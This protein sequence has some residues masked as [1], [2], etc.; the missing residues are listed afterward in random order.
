[1]SIWR[2]LEQFLGMLILRTDRTLLAELNAL[3]KQQER[4]RDIV[5]SELLD[6]ALRQRLTAEKRLAC[7]R[8]LTPRQQE[9]TALICLRY[10]NK[11]IAR[12]LM[13]SPATVSTHIR[14]ILEKFN[15]H[16]KSELRLHLSEWDFSKWDKK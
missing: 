10:T 14:N 8:E 16:S 11:Q 1:M 5:A 3:A 6:L 9:V 15:L 2:P 7:W 4:P 13:I 12:R